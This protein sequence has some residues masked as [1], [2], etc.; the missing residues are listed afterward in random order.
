MTA[1]QRKALA[2]AVLDRAAV[3]WLH[4]VS[5]VAHFANGSAIGA[6]RSLCVSH[7]RQRMELEGAGVLLDE[8]AAELARLREALTWA[9]RF[10]RCNVPAAG[11][12]P[13]FRNADGLLR[14]VG[15]L[16]HGEFQLAIS[17]AEV[18]E[19]ERDRLK[20]FCESLESRLL[21][22]GDPFN[23]DDWQLM[24]DVRAAL[25]RQEQAK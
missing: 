20:T 13:D 9:V 6:V 21:K 18:A 23:G 16:M 2:S 22:D 25:G 1:L 12:Y 15:P 10:I 19:Y 3:E 5:D 8:N 7:E 24:Q 14:Q 17:R 11:E 4:T